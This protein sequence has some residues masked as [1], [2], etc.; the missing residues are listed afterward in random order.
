MNHL[1]GRLGLTALG[2]AAMLMAAP[3]TTSPALA[4]TGLAQPLGCDEGSLGEG[5]LYTNPELQE[6]ALVSVELAFQCGETLADGRYVP[7]GYRVR[8]TRTCGNANACELPLAFA[9]PAN[10]RGGLYQAHVVDDTGTHNFRFRI[11]RRG[12]LMVT[13]ITRPEGGGERARQQYSL[14]PK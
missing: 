6:G 3:M 5:G 12:I 7:T 2:L 11:N 8:I 4:Q 1:T 14:R 9:T 13:E 10:A